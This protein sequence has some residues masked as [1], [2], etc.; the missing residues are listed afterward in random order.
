MEFN[1]SK[2]STSNNIKYLKACIDLNPLPSPINTSLLQSGPVTRKM[3]K[4]IS[5]FFT[6]AN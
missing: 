4:Y 2:D 6:K 5:N 1:H 3:S